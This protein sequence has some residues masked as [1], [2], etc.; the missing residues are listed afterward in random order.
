MQKE[1]K[2]DKLLIA[3]YVI[4]IFS[5]VL[6]GCLVCFTVY[7]LK[8]QKSETVFTE[9]IIDIKEYKA[10]SDKIESEGQETIEIPDVWVDTSSLVN[11]SV[12]LDVEYIPQNPELPT[13][14][15]IT[16][17][18]TVLNYYGY[19]ISKTELSEKYLDK[20][21]APADW[22]KVFVG[23]PTDA[24]SFGCYSYPIVKAANRFLSRNGALHRAVNI[25]RCGFLDVLTEVDNGKPVII[26]GT[27]GLSKGVKTIEWTVDGKKLRWIAPEHCMVLIGYD[28]D[29]MV[30]VV[31]DPQKGIVEY[32]IRKLKQ[33]FETM[34][35]Q[36]VIIETNE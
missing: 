27:Q 20:A 2:H 25:S 1:K 21:D 18:A 31:S 14:C 29:R 13:G 30:A 3:A 8:N 33:S 7:Y 10:K 15:E 6:A 34:Y 23:D 16:S 28:L 11:R 12:R 19:E 26:W 24:H 32:N 9:E 17:L 36:C 5:V 35:S 4:L 22:R